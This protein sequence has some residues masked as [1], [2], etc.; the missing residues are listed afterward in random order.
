MEKERWESEQER[1][2]DNE[3][4]QPASPSQSEKNGC[5]SSAEEERRAEARAAETPPTDP[6]QQSEADDSDE[7]ADEIQRALTGLSRLAE[8]KSRWQ[9]IRA[10]FA[11]LLRTRE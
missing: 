8:S 10:A 9:R 6:A 11:R 1:H 4:V 7:L 5:P 2:L 3:S